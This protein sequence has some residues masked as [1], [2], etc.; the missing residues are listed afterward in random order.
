MKMI[1][2][3]FPRVELRARLEQ[4]KGQILRFAPSKQRLMNNENRDLDRPQFRSNPFVFKR[5]P[6]PP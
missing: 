4:I 1:L 3:L 6:N 2:T 5:R